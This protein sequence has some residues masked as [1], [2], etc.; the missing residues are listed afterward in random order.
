MQF[1]SCVT[2]HLV[3]LSRMTIIKWTCL[4]IGIDLWE[5]YSFLIIKTSE[6][7]QEIPQSHT[8]DKLKA[9]WEDNHTVTHCR[10]SKYHKHKTPFILLD[11]QV[12]HLTRDTIWESDKNKKQQ[13]NTQ[14]SQVVS[15]FP[16]GDHKAATNWQDSITKTNITRKW[17]K[18]STKEATPWN[19]QRKYTQKVRK[20]SSVLTYVSNTIP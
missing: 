15:P 8:E 6:Y 16:A 2:P 3:K 9:L 20:G 7:D 11:D 18:W 17:Q 10:Q 1:T 13:H 4:Y 5:A 12:P 14:K 19:G